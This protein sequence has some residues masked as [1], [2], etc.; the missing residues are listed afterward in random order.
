MFE[1]I[2]FCPLSE[3]IIDYLEN[4]SGDRTCAVTLFL[5]LTSFRAL[6]PNLWVMTGK[7]GNEAIRC[8]DSMPPYDIKEAL[9]FL[10]YWQLYCWWIWSF[11]YT[12]GRSVC[13]QEGF[14]LS[15]VNIFHMICTFVRY[16]KILFCTIF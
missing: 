1:K 8:C 4:I 10:F 9:S 7:V 2:L 3:R 15:T 13:A 6:L 14:L 5:T 12:Y 16:Y 11:C